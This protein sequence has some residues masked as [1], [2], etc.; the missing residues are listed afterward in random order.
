MVIRSPAQ[1][2]I[3]ATDSPQSHHPLLPH[4]QIVSA[5]CHYIAANHIQS[6]IGSSIGD[7]LG[8]GWQCLR[9]IVKWA[10]A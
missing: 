4:H 10:Y 2:Q 3:Y 9:E 8:R 5:V 6:H 7:H 1:L